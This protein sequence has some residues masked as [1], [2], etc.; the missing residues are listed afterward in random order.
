MRRHRWRKRPSPRQSHT[1]QACLSL[2]PPP[3]F[4]YLGEY[5]S[6][7][8]VWQT[9]PAGVPQRRAHKN[10]VPPARSNSEDKNSI[11]VSAIADLPPLRR[12]N[13]AHGIGYAGHAAAIVHHGIETIALLLEARHQRAVERAAA[14]QLDAHRIDEAAVDQNFIM[15]MGP[16]R[17]P[18]R[19]DEADQLALPHPFADLEPLGE[20]RHVAVGGL[21][22]VVVLQLDVFAVAAFQ[23]GDFDDA[24]AGCKNRRAVGGGPVD[25]GMHL[26]VTENGMAAPSSS[27][28]KNT[29]KESPG[30]TLRWKSTS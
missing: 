20:R 10:D 17:L 16:G 4:F 18:G 5:S 3:K 28:A 13:R 12:A 30:C 8:V 21:V 29:S 7:A 11:E 1:V 9:K 22:T 23:A 14:R 27:P 24:V 19:T 2:T 15:D 26:D 25:A 6:A